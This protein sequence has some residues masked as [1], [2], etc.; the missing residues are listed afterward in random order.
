MSENIIE[1]LLIAVGFQTDEAS[2]QKVASEASALKGMLKKALGAV[3][4][5]LSIA[6][7]ANFARDA[8]NAAST[9][10]QMEE[11][12]HAVFLDLSDEADQWAGNLAEAIGRSKNSIKT[13]LADQ[14]NLLVGFGMARDQAASM[15]EEMVSAAINIA[16]FNNISD[17]EAV[18]ALSKAMMGETECAKRLGAVLNDNT[19]AM[20]MEDLGYKQK[21]KN[22]DEATKMQVRYHSIVMQSPD[23]FRE[24]NGVIGDAALSMG[25]Y[26]SKARNLSAIQ[27]DIKENIGSALLPLYY[28]FNSYLARGADKIR[29]LTE[30]MMDSATNG[31]KL[32]K[33]YDLINKGLEKGWDLLRKV[34]DA[35][36]RAVD[37][38]GGYEN[39]LKLLSVAIGTIVGYGLIGKVGGLISKIGG[40]SAVLGGVN[41][42]LA[43]M[44]LLVTAV[45]LIFDDL[46]AFMQGRDSL[47]GDIIDATGGDQQKVRDTLNGIKD[48]VEG[49]FNGAKE[50][51]AD[52]S[53]DI[54]D[55]ADGLAE[56]F[57]EKDAGD[58]L[59]NTLTN[60]KEMIKAIAGVAETAAGFIAFITGAD[61]ALS[62]EKNVATSKGTERMS[63]A[64]AK[65]YKQL[66]H[67]IK[68]TKGQERD[69]IQRQIDALESKYQGTDTTTTGQ[70]WMA[71]G[72]TGAQNSMDRVFN[73]GRSQITDRSWNGM[74]ENTGNSFKSF[75]NDITFGI[76]QDKLF[77]PVS[78]A[79]EDTK[80]AN[81]DT[82]SSTLKAQ[83]GMLSATQ[84]AMMKIVDI[85]SG[86]MAVLMNIDF[87]G[88]NAAG[89]AL[90]GVGAN[91]PVRSAAGK[92]G[93]T[94][95]QTNS[96]NNSFYGDT[97]DNQ[98]AASKQLT[99]DS[100]DATAKMSG[101]LAAGR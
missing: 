76:F 27:K 36:N 81:K 59:I 55:A 12:F 68:G 46:I 9:V 26:E 1:K 72:Q 80:N 53:D 15:S 79:S 19:I 75:L 5:T 39:A 34:Y 89:Y 88:L 20:A 98:V 47:L 100:K 30:R 61:D 74:M 92:S 4:I 13:Y 57:G 3:G 84:N 22:L 31:G 28:T 41:L 62:G 42:K 8:V 14:Q 82:K 49:F 54:R 66:T 101:G 73:G 64:D 56:F 69:R 91:M 99:K 83:D 96:F 65:E 17:D 43:G 93:A 44:V 95:Y 32:A 21:F 85:M 48:S 67:D 37:M 87:S 90:S 58:M 78:E 11:K 97:R 6:G 23:A 24:E 77:P 94:V 38:V 10:E 16:S 18:N 52:F 60:I 86:A 29:I 71:E 40:L 63:N 45:F 25:T 2:R 70:K 33:V 50:K 35:G 7:V 51:L